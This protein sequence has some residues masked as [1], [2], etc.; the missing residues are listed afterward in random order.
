M[1]YLILI[2]SYD[3]RVT[4]IVD[5]EYL[6]SPEFEACGGKVLEDVDQ[7]TD[8][9]L[10]EWNHLWCNPRIDFK[11]ALVRALFDHNSHLL[12]TE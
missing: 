12:D 8:E 1:L 6:N 3:D 4:Q 9:Q 10:E 5:E 2:D 7:L 11:T